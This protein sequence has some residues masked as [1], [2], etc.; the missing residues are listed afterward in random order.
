MPKEAKARMAID[1]LLRRSRRR[2]FDDQGGPANV[3]LQAHVKLKHRVLGELHGRR[4]F[5][6]GVN[7]PWKNL[8]VS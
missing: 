7:K 8:S 5:E 3:T 2:L 4:C 1:N 6:E